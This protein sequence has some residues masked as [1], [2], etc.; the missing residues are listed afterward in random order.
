MFTKLTKQQA[1]RLEQRTLRLSLFTII[2]LA[3]AGIGF[4]LYI[5]SEAVMLDGFFALTSLVSSGLYLVAASVVDKPADRRFQ[6]GYAHI[7][8]LVNCFNNM[9]LLV[10]L[11]YALFNGLE[12]LRTGGNPVDAV[13]VMAYSVLSGAVC[14]A[15]WWYESRVVRRTE[16]QLIRNDAREWMISMGFSAVTLIAF[17]MVWVLPEPARGW[18]AQYADS[19]VL[20][21]LAL[22]LIPVPA[23]ILLVNLREVLLITRPDDQIV[24]RVEAV[25]REIADKH[26]ITRYSVHVA[27]T[28]RI[29]FIEINVLVGPAF[30]PQGVPELDAL[31]ERIWAVIGLPLE[32]VWLGIL[33]TADSRWS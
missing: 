23:K 33:F 10:M 2:G 3:C 25:M 22:L 14:A 11:L 26:D 28:G 21:L 31:R 17:A 7:E 18:W 20:S 32:Q 13:S 12:G 16:S 9:I 15:V 29:H 8:P 30:K 19:A 1:N 5:G 27:K 6:Y 24:Q 4:G